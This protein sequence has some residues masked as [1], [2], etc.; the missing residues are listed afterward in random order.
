MKISIALLVSLAVPFL[1]F[2]EGVTPKKPNE[3]CL[4]SD[5]AKLAIM[6]D[7]QRKEFRSKVSEC[8]RSD[9]TADEVR[10]WIQEDRFLEQSALM[11]I[12]TFV[13]ES[14]K[15]T[16]DGG[17][18]NETGRNGGPGQDLT[19]P[20]RFDSTEWVYSLKLGWEDKPFVRDLYLLRGRRSALEK[21]ELAGERLD[22]WR[23]GFVDAV[24]LNASYSYGSTITDLDGDNNFT[25]KARGGYE[26]KVAYTV[27][28]ETA[29]EAWG[30]AAPLHED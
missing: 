24:T 11:G 12:G 10:A 17:V 4:V 6:T 30:M 16:G 19:T 2:A 26:V 29:F 18:T 20:A 8:W 9:K 3:E 14:M 25:T 15:F 21:Y 27:P 7:E 28:L 23:W 1:S 5:A 22:C 13:F